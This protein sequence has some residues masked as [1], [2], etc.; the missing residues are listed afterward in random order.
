[1]NFF[2][3][4]KAHTDKSLECKLKI[5]PQGKNLMAEGQGENAGGDLSDLVVDVMSKQFPYPQ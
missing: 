4:N 1:M 5:N 3:G 2:S